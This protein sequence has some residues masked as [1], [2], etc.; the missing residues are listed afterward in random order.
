MA[1]PLEDRGRCAHSGR[2]RQ[3]ADEQH[4]RD[5]LQ[6]D[7]HV[8]AAASYEGR[9]GEGL[10]G[11]SP[12]G[13][14]LVRSLRLRLRRWRRPYLDIAPKSGGAAE[15]LQHALRPH[16]GALQR[17]AGQVKDEECAPEKEGRIVA[18]LVAEA[19][20]QERGRARAWIGKAGGCCRPVGGGRA[21]GNRGL[22]RGA[23]D[24]GEGVYFGFG[25]R[26]DGGSGAVRASAGALGADFT[27]AR[28]IGAG[29][30]GSVVGRPLG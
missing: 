17:G 9:G 28:A 21:A 25:L 2:R 11:T 4:A 12:R 19:R 13:L 30:Q 16:L 1:R 29:G 15:A 23:G 14:V 27:R 3:A 5:V 24:G 6:G 26:D 7:Q 20:L 18:G 10:Q 22:G 8:A